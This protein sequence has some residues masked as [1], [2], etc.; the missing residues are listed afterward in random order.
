MKS[1]LFWIIGIIVAFIGG[2]LL[3]GKADISGILPFALALLCPL[4]M[5]FMMG[6]HGGHK[7]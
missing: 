5:I 2:G 4:M 3:I 7:K 1:H 6:S